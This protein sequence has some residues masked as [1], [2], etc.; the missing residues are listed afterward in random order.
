MFSKE[1]HA[2][3]LVEHKKTHHYWFEKKKVQL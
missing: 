1:D 3:S 2:D